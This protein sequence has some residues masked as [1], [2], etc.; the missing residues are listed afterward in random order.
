MRVLETDFFETQTPS[1]RIKACIVSEYFPDYCKIITS[2]YPPK[3]IRYIDLFAG[4]GLYGD[5]SVSTPILVARRCVT[6]EYLKSKVRFIF[7]DN[8]HKNSLQHNFTSEFPKGTF[9]NE[10]RFG[11]KTVG[12]D[13]AIRRFLRLNTHVDSRNACPALLFVDPFGYKGIET[14]VLAKFMANW[15][16]ELFLFVNTK[17]IHPALENEKFHNLMQDLFPTTLNS[18]RRD[19]RFKQ[20]TSE[21]VSLIVN[22]LARE[23]EN[24]LGQK[25]YYTA[26]KFLEEDS[27]T[28]SHYILHLTKSSRGFD[29]VKQVYNDFANVG[30]VFDG[31][32]TYTFDAKKLIN[33]TGEL[34][35]FNNLNIEKLKVDLLQ[36]YGKR[37]ITAS[38]LFEEHQKNSLYTRTHYVQALRQLVAEHKV[39][40]RFTDGK[41]HRKT[42]LVS[43]ACE[44]HFS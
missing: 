11:D 12:E 3:E 37:T 42:V 19:R 40:S 32:N 38:R 39:R 5:G 1:S 18:V 10:P 6:S 27:D 23:Y 35:D 43:E 14:E 31:V 21:R 16:N 13:D 17:R 7:N 34:F 30:T 24:L 26:F 41:E 36:K 29:L 2:R 9:F 4:P 15:G 8:F 33:K 22:S 20:N 28:T 44:L 25:V